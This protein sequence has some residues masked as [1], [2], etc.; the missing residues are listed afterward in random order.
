MKRLVGIVKSIKPSHYGFILDE[1]GNEYFF[2]AQHYRGDWE[3]LISIS[4]PETD[5]GPVVSFDV[6]NG[7][8]GLKAENVELI[9]NL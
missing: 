8:K 5:K 2:H 4:P 3:E 7:P 6:V 1:Q 9:G